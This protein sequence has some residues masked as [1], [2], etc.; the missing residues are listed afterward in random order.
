M[1]EDN[2]LRNRGRVRYENWRDAFLADPENRRIYE[3]EAHNK[4]LWLQLVEARQ[5]VGLTQ[6]QLA[7]RMGV[8]QAQIARLEKRGYE[9]YTLQTL[10][11]YLEA[12]GNDYSLQ[13]RIAPATEAATTHRRQVYRSRRT[14]EQRRRR[15]IAVRR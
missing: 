3:E 1:S 10:R 13:V 8:S 15:T 4:E 6:Q 12:L 5:A 11:R 9:N 2:D 14:L 7:E